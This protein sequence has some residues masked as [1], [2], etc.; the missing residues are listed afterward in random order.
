MRENINFV[1]SGCLIF[2]LSP[3]PCSIY[4]VQILFKVRGIIWLSTGYVIFQ[5][6]EFVRICSRFKS[7]D[8]VAAAML[9]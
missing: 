7:Y 6:E 4:A 8:L 5:V 2:R 9:F 1:R 3:S